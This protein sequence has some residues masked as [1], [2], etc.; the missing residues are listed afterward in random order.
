MA[1]GWESKAVESQMEAAEARAS[2]AKAVQASAEQGAYLLAQLDQLRSHPTVGDVR[3]IG[4]MCAV[5]LVKSKESKEPWG[6]RHEFIK[7]LGETAKDVP[8]R[9]VL[10]HSNCYLPFGAGDTDVNRRRAAA[11][12]V[13]RLASW[14]HRRPCCPP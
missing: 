4:L 13:R 7:Q 8:I 14:N 2:Q 10:R 6:T 1:R 11:L 12:V 5:D 3:G 9:I